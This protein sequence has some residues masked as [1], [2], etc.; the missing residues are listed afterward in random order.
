MRRRTV[1]HVMQQAA[2]GCASV[3]ALCTHTT[4]R[5]Q[6]G[7]V[8]LPPVVARTMPRAELGC[9]L[10]PTDLTFEAEAPHVLQAV[11]A[12]CGVHALGG[13]ESRCVRLHIPGGDAVDADMFRS[14]VP[15]LEAAARAIPSLGTLS[16]VGV[17][18]TSL[19]MALRPGF[20]REV[21]QAAHPTAAVTDMLT[22]VAAACRAVAPGGR[23]AMLTPYEPSLHLDMVSA[24][25]DATGS[26][27]SQ[28]TC[29]GLRMDAE[30][31][32]ACPSYLA[33]AVEHLAEAASPRVDAALLCCSAMRVCG[34][35]F[36]S[37]LEARVGVPVVTSQQAFLW[38]MLRSAGVKEPVEGYGTLMK[39]H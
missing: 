31:S 11:T 2:T 24:V 23:L 12:A 22:A 32:S 38:H 35:G 27:I 36:I 18:C 8:S 9:I 19:S 5:A 30:I 10:L 37:A 4:A 33:A 14:S 3:A 29:L 1:C 21:L 26:E 6:R 39:H 13:V 20:V 25:G 7:H 16:A 34:P 28:H 15:H 17:A